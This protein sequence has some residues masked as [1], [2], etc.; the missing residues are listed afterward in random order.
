NRYVPRAGGFQ[1]YRHRRQAYFPISRSRFASFHVRPPSVETASD[2]IPFPLSI[3][4]P[5]I[6]NVFPAATRSAGSGRTK[7]DR[8]VK[9]EIGTVS[10]AN[11]VGDSIPPGVA[12]IRYAF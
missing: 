6:V 1:R 8:T 7:I 5:S 11:S 10:F 9:N 4:S 3:A 12:G 2:A